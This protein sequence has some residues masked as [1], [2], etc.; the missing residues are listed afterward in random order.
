MK[1]SIIILSGLLA[2]LTAVT[3][4]AQS[5]PSLLIGS[6]AAGFSRGSATVAARPGAYSIENNAAGMSFIE[7]RMNAGVSFGLWQPSYGNDKVIGAGASVKATDKLAFG[8][9]F[10]YFAQPSY[11]ITTDSG[12]ASRDGQFTPKEFN[13]AVGSSFAVTNYLAVGLTA[14]ML[15][16]SLANDVS[17]NVFGA[18][19]GI[20]F[21]MNGISAVISLNNLGTR[22]K[23]GDN[24]YAQ[25]MMA[26]LGAGYS[27]VFGKHSVSVTAEADILFSG[28]VMAG[29][30]A[31]YSFRDMIFVRGGYH[32]GNPHKPNIPSYASAGLGVKFFGVS[33]DVAYLFGSK[34]LKNSFSLSLGYEF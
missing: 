26:K 2:S 10:K 15:H 12:T 18:D 13:V 6:D 25:P 21:R 19:L 23:F 27:P 28:A 3:A 14:R 5:F 20:Y 9:M 17:A 1:K 11:D 8:A 29:V 31:E 30:G 16:S 7:G 32:Y 24:S 22:A 4:Q 34:I 33:I